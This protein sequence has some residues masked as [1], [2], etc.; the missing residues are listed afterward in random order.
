MTEHTA[1]TI[2]LDPPPT[3]EDAS[4]E[5]QQ[6]A[7][8][9]IEGLPKK[10]RTSSMTAERIAEMGLEPHAL[11]LL[12]RIVTATKD[13]RERARC[14]FV[15]GVIR[16]Q[17]GQFE[18][19]SRCYAA[20]TPDLL[21]DED[22]YFALNNFAYC[23]NRLGRHAEAERI[24]RRA[25]ATD[26]RPFNAH[27][28]LGIALERMGRVLEAADAYLVA[29]KA[30]EHDQRPLRHLR[31]LLANHPELEHERPAIAKEVEA[32]IESAR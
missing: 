19:A 25:I 26:S 9:M 22:R 11:R 29:A 8:K 7:Q 21:E 28:N 6:L 12:H 2:I 30:T 18:A 20:V 24:C 16:E 14:Y 17:T 27:K 31:V 10:G 23:L 3:D 13:S 15:A 5:A 1:D 32:L 4:P